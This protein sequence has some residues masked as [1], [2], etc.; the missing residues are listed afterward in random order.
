VELQGDHKAEVKKVLREM[1]Y[2]LV[3]ET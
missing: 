3:D 1:G 2:R